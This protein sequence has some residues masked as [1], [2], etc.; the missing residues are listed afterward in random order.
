MYPPPPLPYQSSTLA[1]RVRRDAS[2]LHF[3][4]AASPCRSPRHT[5]L[6]AWHWPMLAD[7]ARARALARGAARAVDAWRARGVDDVH[8]LDAG[9]GSGLLGVLVAR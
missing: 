3:T 5:R 2:H 9:A 6:P 7:E 1:L 4:P 8:V